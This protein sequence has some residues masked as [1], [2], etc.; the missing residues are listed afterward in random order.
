MRL[1]KRLIAF[2]ALLMAL[3]AVHAQE[4]CPR[5][6]PAL[7]QWEGKSGKLAMPAEGVIVV[8]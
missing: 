3:L 4:P 8:T 1:L 6:I 5:V 2:C 7:Q